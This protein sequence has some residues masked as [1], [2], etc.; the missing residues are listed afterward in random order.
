MEIE[1]K[2]YRQNQMNQMVTKQRQKSAEQKENS[3]F[4][5]DCSTLVRFLLRI[6]SIHKPNNKTLFML[7]VTQQHH[8]GHAFFLTAWL[9]PEKIR[10]THREDAHHRSTTQL[11]REKRISLENTSNFYRNRPC[12]KLQHF[13]RINLYIEDTKRRAVCDAVSA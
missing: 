11:R 3:N 5:T 6:L 1:K 12:S 2:T 9:L 4:L 10:L 13:S 7:I 8:H